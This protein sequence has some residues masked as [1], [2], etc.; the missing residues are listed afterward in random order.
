LPADVQAMARQALAQVNAETNPAKLREM[1]AQMEQMSG[2][3]PPPVKPAIALVLKRA[4][5]RLALLEKK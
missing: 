1:V 3:A 4:Q 2:Q 5:D